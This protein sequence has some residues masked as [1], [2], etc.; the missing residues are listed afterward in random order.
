MME[1]LKETSLFISVSKQYEMMSSRDQ[2]ALKALLCALA[3]IFLYYGMWSPAQGYMLEQKET[4]E[5]R[6][7]LLALVQENQQTLKAL[8]GSSQSSQAGSLDSQ[9][10][11]SSVTNLAK[12]HGLALKRFEP[13][14]ETEVKVWVEDASFDK[15]IAWLGDLKNSLGVIAEQVSVEK[16]DA[17]GLVSARLTLGT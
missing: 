10:L 13:S 5:A 12:R 17:E 8:S 2:N 9:Q 4:L 7:E 16:E 14:G 15:M 3:L 11:V 1:K 6:R